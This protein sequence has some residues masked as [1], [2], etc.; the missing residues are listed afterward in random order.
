M[1]MIKRIFLMMCMTV[2]IALTVAAQ[3][4][5]DVSEYNEVYAKDA[6][7]DSIHALVPLQ[8][9][10]AKNAFYVNVPKQLNLKDN[11]FVVNNSSCVILQMMAAVDYDGTGNYVTLGQAS[12]LNRG[13]EAKIASFDDNKLKNVRGKNL[14]LKVKGAKIKNN[15]GNGGAQVN[16]DTPFGSVQVVNRSLSYEDVKNIDESQIT[17]E[18]KVTLRESHHDLYILVEDKDILNF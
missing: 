14:V 18:F 6:V 13:G 3:E 4:E 15:V 5:Q 2:C 17:Y 8:G 7:E 9:E 1:A 10:S 11:V 16:V 12:F